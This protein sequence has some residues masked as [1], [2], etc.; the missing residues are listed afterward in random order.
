MPCAFIRYFLYRS[1]IFGEKSIYSINKENGK[2]HNRRN[3]EDS[4]EVLSHTNINIY[5]FEY[6]GYLNVRIIFLLQERASYIYDR[7]YIL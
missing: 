1:C 6:T 7:V 4:I 3:Y 5:R 2:N